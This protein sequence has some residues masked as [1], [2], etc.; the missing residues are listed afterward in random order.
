MLN[1]ITDAAGNLM[2]PPPGMAFDFSEPRGEPA[3]VPANSVSWRIFKNPVSLFVGGVA[4]VILE[5]AEPS[6][7]SGVWEHSSFRKDAAMRL[8]R[9]GF[10]AMM[11]VY[12]PRSAAERMIAHVVQMHQRVQGQTP[13]GTEYHANDPR[14]LDWVQATASFGFIHAYHRFARP[15]SRE[16]RSRAFAE[17]A[18]AARLYGATGAPQ[19]L[20]AW[21]T[22]LEDMRD[23]LEPSPIVRE[24][25]D[26]V[27]K[28]DVLPRPLRPLQRLMVRAAVEITPPWVRERLGLA[29][30]SEGLSR[31]ERALVR[32]MARMAERVPLRTAPPA[33]ASLRMGLPANALYA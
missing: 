27:G 7:R 19:S 12:G 24:F 33:Q 29:G 23:T 6:V 30:K 13:D 1:R 17:G 10:A 21:E 25:L 22:M 4:A 14:L 15:L 9:T 11:T 20:E 28:A 16:Q 26:L 32:M 18:Q 5:L 2:Q 31:P 8:R 3:L